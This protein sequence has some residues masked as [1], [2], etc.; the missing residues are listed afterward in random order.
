MQSGHSN[1]ATC[2]RWHQVL[3]ASQIEAPDVEFVV[4]FVKFGTERQPARKC[5]V[6]VLAKTTVGALK[7][8]RSQVKRTDRFAVVSQQARIT[9]PV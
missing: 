2:R 3:H 1:Q 9:V 4:Q 5:E 8:C 7:I 6:K